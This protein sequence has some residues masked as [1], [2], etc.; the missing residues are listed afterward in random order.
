MSDITHYSFSF[1]AR[2]NFATLSG[3]I[4]KNAAC[5]AGSTCPPSADTG[6]SLTSV[7][8]PASRMIVLGRH[9]ADAINV[10]RSNGISSRH[11]IDELVDRNGVSF[12]DGP[13]EPP[14]RALPCRFGSELGPVPEQP[15]NVRK[16]AQQC[17]Q[18]LDHL[19]VPSAGLSSF[20]VARNLAPASSRAVPPM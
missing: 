19:G 2:I 13:D 11:L 20:G 18:S 7:V 16:R 1:A 15:G 14:Y 5:D 8:T 9:P 4:T 6:Q 10:S 12:H 17:Q 3:L